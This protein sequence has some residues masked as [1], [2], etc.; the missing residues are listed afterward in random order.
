[1]LSAAASANSP[2][3]HYVITKGTALL[4]YTAHEIKFGEYALVCV[5]VG[6]AVRCGSHRHNSRHSDRIDWCDFCDWLLFP[7]SKVKPKNPARN[8]SPAKNVG[9]ESIAR[10]VNPYIVLS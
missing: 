1:M 6:F 3:C 2:G 4:L 10:P 7:L 8:F 9:R 5:C